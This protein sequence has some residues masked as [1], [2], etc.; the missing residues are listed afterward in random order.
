MNNDAQ[1]L[2]EILDLQREQRTLILATTNAAG[3]PLASYAPFFEDGDGCFCIFVSEL[4]GHTSNLARNARIS[5]LLMEDEATSK[6]LFARKRVTY[7]GIPTE[8]AR[9]ASD[10]ESL[11]DQMRE[12]HGPIMD[13]LRTLQDFHL[14]RIRPLHAIFVRGFG[15]AFKITGE[16]LREIHHLNDKGHRS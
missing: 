16:D 5:F 1:I 4:S 13:L 6:Q 3:E 15:E 11:L 2:S 7:L 9:D 14:F 12:R 8:V 10:F